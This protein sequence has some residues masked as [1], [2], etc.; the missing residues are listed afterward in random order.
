MMLFNCAC[1]MSRVRVLTLL[2]LVGSKISMAYLSSCKKTWKLCTWKC[3]AWSS[4]GRVT[5][6]RGRSGRCWGCSWTCRKSASLEYWC[7]LESASG[8]TFLWFLPGQIQF[9]IFP[10]N[11][12]RWPVPTSCQRKYSL[13]ELIQTSVDESD[14]LTISHDLLDQA[15]GCVSH[16]SVYGFDGGVD[17]REI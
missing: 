4:P 14:S 7:S 15:V 13:K 10:W 12:A 5:P 6:R 1:C 17:I 11:T 16:P 2:P 3:A 9:S 8:N